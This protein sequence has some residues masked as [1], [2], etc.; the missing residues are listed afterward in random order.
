MKK[1][2]NALTLHIMDKRLHMVESKL[3]REEHKPYVRRISQS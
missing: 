1:S 2:S 3:K